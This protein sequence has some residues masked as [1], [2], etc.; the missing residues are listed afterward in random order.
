MPAAGHGIKEDKYER[1]NI[2]EGSLLRRDIIA[3]ML[4][5]DNNRKHPE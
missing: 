1:I 4:T 2:K 3:D 5:I